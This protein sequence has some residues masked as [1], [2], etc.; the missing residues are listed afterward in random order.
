MVLKTTTMIQKWLAN[1]AVISPNKQCCW[2]NVLIMKRFPEEEKVCKSSDTVDGSLS[3]K[4]PISIE[5][6][7]IIWN[8]QNYHFFISTHCFRWLIANN[9][10]RHTLYHWFIHIFVDYRFLYVTVWRGRTILE[11]GTKIWTHL[12]SKI[13]TH[14][15]MNTY[16]ISTVR[17][18]HNNSC[19]CLTETEA[20]W[21]MLMAQN[22][23]HVSAP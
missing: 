5:L 21:Q 3:E 11:T 9:Q 14:L 4:W 15:N 16:F 12:G 23:W 1:C 2:L 19:Y 6:Q 8:V 13:W 17:S 20:R 18:A 10:W 7:W 22:Q